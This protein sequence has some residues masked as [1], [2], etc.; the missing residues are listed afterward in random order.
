MA[1]DWIPVRIDIHEDPAVIAISVAVGLDEYA[2]VGRLHRLWGWANRH[3]SSGNAPSVTDQW[4]DRYVSAPG[5]A[6]AMLAAGWLRSRSGG[7]EFPNYDRWNSQSAKRRALTAQRVKR[8]RNANGNAPGVTPALPEKRREEDNKKEPPPNP[9]PGGTAGEQ[10]GNHRERKPPDPGAESVPVPGELDRPA[11]LAVWADWLADRK[12]RGKKVTARAARLQLADL[13][14]LGAD[15]AT[16]CVRASITK[17]WTGLFPE[18]FA[19]PAGAG[20]P[21]GKPN[22]RTAE[23]VEAM[24]RNLLNHPSNHGGHRGSL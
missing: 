22:H 7:V 14:P 2:V 19:A 16:E 3:L 17:G 11:F 23:E 12:A 9:P 6:A 24:R 4:I 1:G 13:L 15:R 8:S 18:R 20:S 5:F 10:P 21:G